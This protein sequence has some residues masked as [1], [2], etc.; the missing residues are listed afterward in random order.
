MKI[1]M[2]LVIYGYIFIY[3]IQLS[4]TC[5]GTKTMKRAVHFDD[6]FMSHDDSVL[7]L[8]STSDAEYFPTPQKGHHLASIN[9]LIGS[10]KGRDV[11]PIRAQLHSPIKDVSPSTARYYKK[12]SLQT[13]MAALECIAPGQSNEL[14]EL[15]S[16]HKGEQ[17]TVPIENEIVQKLITL[18]QDTSSRI[19]RLE[20]LSIFAQDYSKSQL[21]QMI[22][23]ITMWR[24]DEARKHAALYGAGTTKEIPKTHRTRMNPV[25]VDHFIDFI[26]QPH[27]LQDVAFGTRT[28]KLSSGTTLEIPNVIRTVTSSRLVD[29]YVKTCKESDFEHLE[30]STLFSILKLFTHQYFSV[31]ILS[32]SPA[33][34]YRCT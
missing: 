28:L 11:S 2:D 26:S 22:P 23:G 14:F 18:Y 4:A 21:K 16:N 5:S 32:V 15:I 27:F 1:I 8:D 3:I 20:I 19:T 17:N 25:K 7:S 30:R 10:V 13:C 34:V 31:V 6:S 9:N 24:I 33:I 12:K 29:L